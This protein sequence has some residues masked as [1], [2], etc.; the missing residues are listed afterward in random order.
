MEGAA[1]DLALLIPAELVE[2]D[3][4]ARNADG[5]VGVGIRIFIGVDQLLPVQHIDV[6]VVGPVDEISVQNGDQVGRLRLPVG[7]QGAGYED[8]YK[9]QAMISPRGRPSRSKARQ[10]TSSASVESSPPEIP[11]TAVRAAVWRRRF[12]SPAACMAKMLSHRASR[13]GP[14]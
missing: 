7:P 1:D 4:I 2:V 11:I 6:D 3:R 8:V 9:R 10:V 5:Q 14:S 13:L 12:C